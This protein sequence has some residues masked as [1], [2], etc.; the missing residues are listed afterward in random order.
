MLRPILFRL[1]LALAWAAT[2]PAAIAQP[3]DPGPPGPRGG[4]APHAPGPGPGPRWHPGYGPYHGDPE[5]WQW[6]GLAGFTLH[7]LDMMTEPQR[8]AHQYAQIQ[9]TSAPIGQRIQWAENGAGGTVVA[10]RD[11]T[12]TATGAYCREFQQEVTIGGR[13]ERSY[14]TACRQP[15]GAWKIVS[16]R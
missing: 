10:L 1:A 13:L 7:L 16:T 8:R 12:D 5:A 2:I 14:G 15:D 6:L 11:G 3:F 4:P 9:A